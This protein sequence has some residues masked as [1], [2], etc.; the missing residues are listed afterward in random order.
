V[1][2]IQILLR[3]IFYLLYHQFAWTY[4]FVAA[5]VSLGR[6]Q[7]WVETVVPYLDGRVLEIGFGPGHLQEALNERGFCSFGLDE[8]PQMVRQATKRLRKR[9]GSIR[10]I[11]GYAQVIPFAEASFDSVAATFPAEYIFDPNTLKEIRR[12]LVPSGQLV[13]IP[14]AWVTGGRVLER[15]VA[16]IFR[17]SGE[18]PGKPHLLSGE[19]KA[20]FVHAGFDTHSEIV[21]KNG[22]QVLVIVAKRM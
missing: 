5:V 12:V 13:I 2:L 22:S 16:W 8:S 19:I 18:A 6:W 4:D 17:V 1:R 20:R 21:V 7:G 14:T 10:L 15:L 3:P 11:R 9:K